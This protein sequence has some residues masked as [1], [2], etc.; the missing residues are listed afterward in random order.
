MSGVDNVNVSLVGGIVGGAVFLTGAA[1]M[2]LYKGVKT[3][4]VAADRAAE[5]A[6]AVEQARKSAMDYAEITE[7]SFRAMELESINT[8]NRIRGA[9]LLSDQNIMSL[10]DEIALI[11]KQQNERFTKQF[12]EYRT[13]F[14]K[15]QKKAIKEIEHEALIASEQMT[16][17]RNDVL[18]ELKTQREAL[19]H[20]IIQQRRDIAA[21][22]QNNNALVSSAAARVDSMEKI[23]GGHQKFAQ[24]WIEQAK[25][26]L[27]GIESLRKENSNLSLASKI[28]EDIGKAEGDMQIQA[29]ESAITAGRRAFQAALDLKERIAVDEIEWNKLNAHLQEQIA[30][31]SEDLKDDANLIYEMET[32]EGIERTPANL[33]YWTNG[34]FSSIQKA[35]DALN[36][37]FSSLEKKSAEEIKKGIIELE[38]IGAELAVLRHMAKANFLFSHN[39]YIQSCH[40]ADLFAENFSMTDSEGTYEGEDQRGAYV[41]IYKNPIT[42]DAIVVKIQPVPDDAGIMNQ[43]RLEVHYFND[44]NNEE[45]REQWRSKING[46]LGG[47]KLSCKSCKGL[48]SDQRQLLNTDW[49][50]QQKQQQANTQE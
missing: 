10:D 43:N 30:N 27:A 3:A 12:R 19:E 42:N 40:F 32:S 13:D 6:N 18:H 37:S 35:F 7:R 38:N 25:G 33:D 9:G 8:S 5:R 21:E 29:Y 2:L 16:R 50:K 1:V 23:A 22:I 44:S 41:G 31:I 36:A 34:K 47:K 14:N 46:L 11:N 17:L 26:L 28:R 4:V 20:G 15:W 39:R 45:Q 24:Y 49:V 48:P